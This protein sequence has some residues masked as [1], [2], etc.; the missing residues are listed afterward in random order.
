MK[1]IIKNY[2]VEL[3]LL[4]VKELIRNAVE[5]ETG[6]YVT[7]IDFSISGGYED[8]FSSTPA[9]LTKVTVKLGEL[10]TSSRQVAERPDDVW[11]RGP[12]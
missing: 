2:S 5:Q 6:R 7:S 8:R 11:G 3:G 10:I 1:N 9:A 12:G 4:D